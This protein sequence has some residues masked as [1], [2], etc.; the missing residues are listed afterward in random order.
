M[1]N[2]NAEFVWT[3]PRVR[4][5]EKPKWHQWNTEHISLFVGKIFNDWKWIVVQI[6]TGINIL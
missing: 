6:E 3:V 1:T 2:P 4:Q 5:S